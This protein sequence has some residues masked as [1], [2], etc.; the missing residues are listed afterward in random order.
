MSAS[1]RHKLS[2]VKESLVDLS[3]SMQARV[4]ENFLHCL[5]FLENV[6]KQKNLLI[7]RQKL[8]N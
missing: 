3:L 8:M 6:K 1:M 2:T 7:G 5:R 4:G